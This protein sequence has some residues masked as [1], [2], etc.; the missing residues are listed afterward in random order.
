MITNISKYLKM[1]L[2]NLLKFLF[3]PK[4]G[5]LPVVL[6]AR[7]GGRRAEHRRR[8]IDYRRRCELDPSRL[9]R[10]RA[11]IGATSSSSDAN[12]WRFRHQ[13]AATAAAT[14]NA[15]AARATVRLYT[16]FVERNRTVEGSIRP[17][18]PRST[19]NNFHYKKKFFEKALN[20]FSVF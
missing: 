18:W 3:P 12:S 17:T 7:Y 13:T 1:S 14:R 8:R 6:E 19:F 11:K 20:K 4:K 15:A 16:A 2:T 9:L 10:L 5:R